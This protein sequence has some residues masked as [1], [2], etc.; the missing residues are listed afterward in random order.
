LLL[1]ISGSACYGPK[2]FL[3]QGD[4]G[5]AQVGYYG[6]VDSATAVAR[7]HCA[8]YERVPHF[9]EAAENVAFFECVRP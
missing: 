5:S 8:R 4:A 1:A 2:P 9:L 3:L 7:Q 6:E